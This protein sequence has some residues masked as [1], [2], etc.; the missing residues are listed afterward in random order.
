MTKD[1]AQTRAR[2]IMKPWPNLCHECDEDELEAAIASALIEAADGS[3]QHEHRDDALEYVTAPKV[4]DDAEL[5]RA[6]KEVYDTQDDEC[7]PNHAT[8]YFRAGAHHA[9]RL[10]LIARVEDVWVSDAEINSASASAVTP[11]THTMGFELTKEQTA[12]IKGASWILATL[13]K[14]ISEE[15]GK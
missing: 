4:I 6:A 10:G 13:R 14:R 12:F 1:E 3:W 8:K 2:E 11:G 15:G 5:E 9:A 7:S